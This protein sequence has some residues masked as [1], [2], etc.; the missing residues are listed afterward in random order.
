M[1]PPDFFQST[2][3]VAQDG[4]FLMLELIA[5]PVLLTQINVVSNWFEELSQRVPLD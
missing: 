1:V 4:R 5:E 3:D 2:Y